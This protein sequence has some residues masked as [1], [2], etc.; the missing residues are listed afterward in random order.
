MFP[1]SS[2]LLDIVLYTFQCLAQIA[3]GFVVA[4]VE[5]Y[6]IHLTDGAPV[7]VVNFNLHGLQNPLPFVPNAFR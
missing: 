1:I 5:E 7:E 3:L 2:S 4:L 6:A